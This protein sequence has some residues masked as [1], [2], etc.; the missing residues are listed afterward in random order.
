MTHEADPDTLIVQTDR[1]MRAFFPE[2]P[3]V[4]GVA[5]SGGGDSTAL[6]HLLADWGRA[7]G[8]EIRALSVDHGLRAEARAE[9]AQA[10][11]LCRTLDI[12]H[13]VADWH[14]DGQG[15]LQDAARRGRRARL[16]GWARQAGL[17]AVALGHTADDQAETVL[18]RLARGSGVDGLAGMAPEREAEGVRFI[19]PLLGAG[20]A[21]LRDYLRARGVAWSDDP[22]NDD[23]RFDRVRARRMLEALAPLGL[24]VDRLCRTAGHMAR[25]QEVLERAAADL[26]ARAVRQEAGDLI[27][28]HGALRAAPRDTA[29][30][31]LSQALCW[32]SASRYRPR[33]DALV[34][35]LDAGTP[36]ALHGCLALRDEE[37]LRLVREPSAVTDQEAAPGAPWDGRWIVTGPHVQG[38]R[39]RMLGEEGLRRVPGWRQTNRPRTALLSSPAVWMG[40]TLIAAPL[41]GWAQGWQADLCPEWAEFPP[42]RSAAMQI[43]R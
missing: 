9:I 15:N 19:R 13:E 30:R 18:M 14:W 40:E 41:A 21:A 29:T 7:Q 8:V 36:G 38:A 3:G 6:V 2:P 1:A 27:L 20:R 10:A 16:A 39:V 22:S 35:M 34:T 28:D 24:S 4:I 31:V 25:A 26:A 43:S 33:Y 37:G 5:L 17:A 32:V 12:P 11:A 42:R 23:P